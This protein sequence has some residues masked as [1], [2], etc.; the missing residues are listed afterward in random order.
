MGCTLE[1]MEWMADV[2][3]ESMWATYILYGR[4]LS[5]YCYLLPNLSIFNL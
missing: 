1:R 3:S 5:Y 2:L 4:F